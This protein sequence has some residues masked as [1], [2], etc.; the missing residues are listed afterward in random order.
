MNAV[1]PFNIELVLRANVGQGKAGLADFKDSLE[2]VK[3]GATGAAAATGAQAD[4]LDRMAAATARAALSQE[5]LTTAERRAAEARQRAVSS[6]VNVLAQQPVVA[7]AGAWRAAETSAESLRQTVSGL[8]ISL[9]DSVRDMMATTVESRSYRQALDEIRASFNPLFA[10]SRQY[11]EQLDRIARAESAGAISAREAAA[12]RERAAAIIAPM[13]T[14]GRQ[15][16]GAMNSAYTS[17]VAAQGFDIGVTAAMGMNPMMIGLQ[18]GTQIAQVAT[19]MGG[20]MQAVRGIAAGFASILSPMTLATIAFTGLGAAG[21]QA[22]MSLRRETKT[23]ASAMQELE[24]S[25]DRYAT[26]GARARSSA[27]D[28]A[29]EFGSASDMARRLLTDIAE[30]DRRSVSRGIA[31]TIRALPREYGVQLDE[32]AVPGASKLRSLFDI[33]RLD[34][35]GMRLVHGIEGAMKWA[36]DATTIEQQIR[37]LEAVHERWKAAAQLSGDMSRSEE[38]G[39]AAIQSLLEQLG[40]VLATDENA[41][42]TAQAE[43]IAKDLERRA[44]LERAILRYGRESAEVRA[45]ENRQERDAV[46]TKLEELGI[47]RDSAEAERVL[48][49]LAEVQAARAAEALEARRA[50][51]Q[52]K[53]DELAA[54]RLEISLIGA[55][56]AEAERARAIAEAEL[57]IRDRKLGLLDAIFARVQAIA[58]AEAEAQLERARALDELRRDSI[59]D[60]FD[61]RIRRTANPY[62]RADLEAQKEYVRLVGEGKDADLAAAEAARI[63]A[64]AIDEANVAGSNYLRDQ[65][66][67]LAAQRLELALLGQTEAVRARVLALVRAEQDIRRL[68]LSGDAAETA[69]RGAT[70]QADLARAIEMQADAWKT[71]QSAG[72]AAIDGVLDRLRDGDAKGALRGL[73]DEIAT[74]F[75]DLNVRNPIK[76][77]LLETNLG[78]MDS[79]GGLQGIWSRLTGRGQ[80]DEPSLVAMGTA[81]VQAMTVSAAQVSINATGLN[82]AGLSGAAANLPVAPPA[83]TLGSGGL[84]GPADIQAQVWRF[85]AAK[86]L[87]PH[88]I[89]G[90]M[91]NVSAE[92]GFNPMAV[93][94]GGTSFG[95][96]QHHA[97]RGRGLLS[98]LGGADNLGNVQ[99]QLDYVWKEL[100]TNEA[101]AMRRLMASTTVRGATE[102]FV[103]FER[104]QGYTAQNP[105]GALHFDRRLAAAEA[106]MGR[107]EA[108]TQTAGTQLAQFG[109]GAVQVG[110][111]LAQVGS[112]LAGTIR[113]I[114]AQHGIG[115][116]VAGTLLTGLGQWIGIP[117]FDRGG[118]TGAGDPSDIGGLVHKE[119]FVFDAAAT[120]RI[121]VRNL[122]AIRRGSM[123]GFRSGGFVTGGRPPSAPGT[124]ATTSERSSVFNINVTGTGNREVRDG[125]HA[126]IAEALDLYDRQ[127]LPDRVKAIVSD[128]WG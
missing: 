38:E 13:S 125:V 19:Q 81:A 83:A 42:G 10:A 71:V 103:G 75:F 11:E 53:Q 76:N 93:G 84:P 123:R 41:A 61:A 98:S 122:E 25:A 7:S 109:E 23:L 32:H 101:A 45:I 85:F 87:A 17:N 128:R 40:K 30:L 14:G 70:A 49:A 86:G 36:A 95:L 97:G 60:G 21:I 118:W 114:G 33:G 102:A 73:V 82:L 111:G 90:I 54:I 56:N 115:G 46:R 16:A 63:R 127:G 91:G 117:G 79:V 104:P 78:T 57:E 47:T 31:D 105:E 69:R 66:E 92:S 18:Q 99:G 65:G 2:G 26:S 37:A 88:Q 34:R 112:T 80:L 20:G 121:G 77:A 35:E 3:T 4:A 1:S 59:S 15:G 124:A 126:A 24:A 120:R 119:E 74:A 27:A 100:M 39:L 110:A 44:E 51:M 29:V 43:L 55:S 5:D 113:G 9:G 116:A 28:L 12:A 62:L 94:D 58:R 107:F 72:E 106:S 96:F 64:R 22:L 8:N 50:W 67:Q 48:A 6:P 52:D 108:A 68:G 89:A